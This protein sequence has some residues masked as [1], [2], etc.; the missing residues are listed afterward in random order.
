[1]HGTFEF[2]PCVVHFTRA[3]RRLVDLLLKRE[4]VTHEAAGAA[5]SW[6]SRRPTMYRVK[7]FNV[8]AI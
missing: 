5:T 8:L 2:T 4:T 7:K 3:E 1:M 6:D